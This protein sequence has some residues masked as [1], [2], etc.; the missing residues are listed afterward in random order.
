MPYNPGSK[1]DAGIP[2]YFQVIRTFF[3]RPAPPSL[4]LFTGTIILG[5]RQLFREL[6]ALSRGSQPSDAVSFATF[7]E[8]GAAGRTLAPLRPAFISPMTIR[9]GNDMC[10]DRPAG[11]EQS[12]DVFQRNG[13]VNSAVISA[14]WGR[15]QCAPNL[16]VLSFVQLLPILFFLLLPSPPGPFGVLLTIVLERELTNSARQ[17]FKSRVIW[18]RP[19]TLCCRRG[20]RVSD[21]VANVAAQ[22]PV[23]RMSTSSVVCTSNMC[24]CQCPGP[25]EH[26]VAPDTDLR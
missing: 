8:A 9:L 24:V 10:P 5:F 12:A 26:L 16:L 14:Q 7:S 22:Q 21:D 17:H 1:L 25:V 19:D 23:R 6:D 13:A 20:G 4:E 3:E 18:W 15:E 2:G 11:V